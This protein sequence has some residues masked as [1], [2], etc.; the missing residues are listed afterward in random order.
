MQTGKKMCLKEKIHHSSD[1]INASNTIHPQ[2]G[3]TGC[4]VS[5][6]K[7]VTNVMSCRNVFAVNLRHETKKKKSLALKSS[8]GVVKVPKS[9][10]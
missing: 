10:K 7:V 5:R 6:L 1:N 2:T 3:Q 4:L 8:T 9:L